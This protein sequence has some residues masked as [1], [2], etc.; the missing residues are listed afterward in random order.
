M[1]QRLGHAM[2]GPTQLSGCKNGPCP[3]IFAWGD[4]AAVQGDV[5]TE[6]TTMLSAGVDEEVVAI[7]IG[8]LIEALAELGLNPNSPACGPTVIPQAGILRMNDVLVVRGLA[9]T[10]LTNQIVPGLGEAVV[11]LPLDDLITASRELAVIK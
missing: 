11:E 3:K 4:R 2:T 1:A 7:P 5:G 10:D 9:S 6:L 8:I